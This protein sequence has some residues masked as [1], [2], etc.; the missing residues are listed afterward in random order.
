MLDRKTD[1]HTS[2]SFGCARRVH[3][4][5]HFGYTTCTAALEHRR[6]LADRARQLEAAMQD[7]VAALASIGWTVDPDPRAEV[8]AQQSAPLASNCAIC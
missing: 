5:L 3:R 8:R 4:F 2:S 7:P 6:I 1:P